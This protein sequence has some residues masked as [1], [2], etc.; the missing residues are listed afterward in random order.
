MNKIIIAF[1]LATLLTSHAIAEASI[2][3]S[4]PPDVQNDIKKIRQTCRE[5]KVSKITEGNRTCRFAA[6]GSRTKIDDDRVTFKWKDYR[7]EGPESA[8]HAMH[9]RDR[10]FLHN[11]RKK[12]PVR[13]GQLA[14]PPR[15]R[16]V[17]ETVPP[18]LIEPDHP[19]PQRLP[20][21]AADFRRFC[22]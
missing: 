10:A 18:L 2:L 11:P 12:R 22:A 21:H 16:S 1:G 14:R 8:H 3:S 20:V 4:L 5:W 6:S 7:I 19:I 17:D 13:V 9:R 15:R